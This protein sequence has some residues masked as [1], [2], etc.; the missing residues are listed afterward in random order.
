MSFSDNAHEE[1]SFQLLKER[2]LPPKTRCQS[3][4]VQ[5]GFLWHNNYD[6]LNNASTQAGK[7]RVEHRSALP[8]SGSSCLEKPR[9]I[10]VVITHSASVRGRIYAAASKSW[11]TCISRAGTAAGWVG[12]RF[13]WEWPPG[14]GAAL[15]KAIPDNAGMWP[16]A[17]ALV[18]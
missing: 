11:S 16:T 17:E 5:I 14:S 3:A 7:W 4:Q 10:Y 1:Q 13:L 8:C 15:G 12:L 9:V 18:V 6:W 2:L